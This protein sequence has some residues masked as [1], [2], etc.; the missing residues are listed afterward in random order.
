M[1]DAS[2]A[3]PHFRRGTKIGQEAT[4]AT[5][6]F[7][8]AN[9]IGPTPSWPIAY[10]FGQKAR[11]VPATA[12]FSF[13]RLQPFLEP[14][15]GLFGLLGVDQAVAVGVDFLEFFPGAQEFLGRDVELGVLLSRRCRWRL[16]VIGWSL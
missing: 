14:G 11:Q 12:P 16:T 2:T 3:A 9:N 7:S 15:V 10:Q 5:R 4:P 1:A 8:L 13:P 6:N